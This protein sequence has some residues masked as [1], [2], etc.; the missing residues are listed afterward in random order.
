MEQLSNNMKIDEERKNEEH[1]L[2]NEEHKLRME[3][4]RIKIAHAKEKIEAQKNF[5][6]YLQNRLGNVVLFQSSVLHLHFPALIGVLELLS[7]DLQVVQD[8]LQ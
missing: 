4:L 6:N 1:K 5:S 7:G 2:R 3:L 8:P